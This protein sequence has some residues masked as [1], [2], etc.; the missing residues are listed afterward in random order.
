MHLGMLIGTTDSHMSLLTVTRE[1]VPLVEERQLYML[2]TA[3]L[4]EN[5]VAY[6]GS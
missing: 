3:R 1:V 4:W 6:S 5:G 2:L